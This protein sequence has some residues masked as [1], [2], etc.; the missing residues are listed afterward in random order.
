MERYKR[1]V[2]GSEIASPH[3]RPSTWSLVSAV[4]FPGRKLREITDHSVER[5]GGSK[6][7]PLRSV[8]PTVFLMPNLVKADLSHA[9]GQTPA[10]DGAGLDTKD[11]SGTVSIASPLTHSRGVVDWAGVGSAAED[12]A[13]A[14][15]LGGGMSGRAIARP[16]PSRTTPSIQAG[17]VHTAVSAELPPWPATS[18]TSAGRSTVLSQTNYCDRQ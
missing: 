6:S 10:A 17:T 15:R 14:S 18:T 7:R 3:S 2:F 5:A 16:P 1:S 8:R 13:A 4:C 9:P 11:S 12:G